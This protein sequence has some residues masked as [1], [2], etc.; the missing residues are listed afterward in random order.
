MQGIKTTPMIIKQCGRCGLVHMIPSKYPV[1]GIQCSKCDHKHHSAAIWQFHLLT[2]MPQGTGSPV[3]TRKT[4][5]GSWTKAIV[6]GPAREIRAANVTKSLGDSRVNSDRTQFG[7]MMTRII[8][9]AVC[10]RTMLH[11]C[12]SLLIAGTTPILRKLYPGI[13]PTC[14]DPVLLGNWESR[15]S[16]SHIGNHLL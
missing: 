9:S 5:A 7:K 1:Y 8:S 16:W 3:G 11:S 15:I 2:L 14:L 10:F 13:G 4:A 6:P 12:S